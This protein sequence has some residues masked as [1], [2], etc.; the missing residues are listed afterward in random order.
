MKDNTINKDPYKRT[1]G[2]YDRMF[3]SMNKGLRVLGIRMFIP[4]R[5]GSIL[6]VGCG[7]GA[8]LEMYQRYG[9]NLYGMDTSPT[10]LKVARER[11]GEKADLIL[12]DAE[13]MPYETA[14]FDLILCML[15][16]HEMDDEV[17]TGVLN[18]MKRVLKEDGR[19]LL[20]D[21]HRGKPRT[22]KGWY[23]KM[24][25]LFAEIAAGRRHFRNYRHYLSIGGLPA[26]IDRG[27]FETEKSKITGEDLLSLY[28][29]KGK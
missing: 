12:A 15:V 27:Q 29:I 18:E 11:L 4:P 14:S 23:Y 20:I 28:L 6:D 2:L 7:T 26:L 10:M 25:I 8:H 22:F 16:L 1:A 17:R 19:V 21:Y 3:E 24:V 9:G 5:G 13:N